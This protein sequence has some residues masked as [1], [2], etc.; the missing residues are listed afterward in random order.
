M[1]DP[2]ALQDLFLGT[3]SGAVI[4]LAGAFYAVFLA[5]AGLQGK[6]TYRIAAYI[7]FG[8]LTCS[9]LVFVDA[10]MLENIWIA[11]AVTMV[12]GYFFL[13]RAVWRLCV[14]THGEDLNEESEVAHR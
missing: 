10:L 3:I 7:A 13:P 14:A 11:V 4:V 1:P 9:V 6:Q 5:L 8:V 2:I 12:I